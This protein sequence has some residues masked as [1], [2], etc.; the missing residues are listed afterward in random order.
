MAEPQNLN[1]AGATQGH[2][3]VT[4][5][6]ILSD[7]PPPP[8]KLKE[9]IETLILFV[10]LVGELAKAAGRLGG[11]DWLQRAR[12]ELAGGRLGAMDP[13]SQDMV[14]GAEVVEGLDGPR[15]WR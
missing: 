2:V 4:M 13:S 3:T 14:L 7:P 10:R 8:G 5:D 12:F 1:V 6:A 15:E 9:D 11:I